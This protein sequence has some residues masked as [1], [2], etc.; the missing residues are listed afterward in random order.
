MLLSIFTPTNNTS[1]LIDLFDSIKRQTYENWEW[2]ILLNGK[3]RKDYLPLVIRQ[4]ERV[5]VYLSEFDDGIIGKLKKEACSYCSGCFFIEVDHDDI[6]TP[7]ALSLMKEAI[8]QEDPD[9][10]YSDFAEFNENNEYRTYS[11][12]YGWQPYTIYP[13]WNGSKPVEV[14]AAFQAD[15][16]S[17]AQIFFAPNHIRAWSRRIYE[18]IGGHDDTL[19]ICDDYDLLCRTFLATAK[20]KYIE[21]C[22]YLYR[23][24][25]DSANT[26]LLRNEEIQKV[27]QN[28]SNKYIYRMIDAW[29]ERNNWR[30]LYIG[31]PENYKGQ[32][33]ETIHP[34]PA[35][36]YREE[37][38]PRLADIPDNSVGVI[39]MLDILQNIPS[40][41]IAGCQHDDFC[42]VALMNELYRILVPG[43]WL[44]TATP[45]TDGRGAWQDP[46]HVSFWNANSFWYYCNADYAKYIANMQCR[47]Q[48]NRCWQ[49]YPSNFH[50]QNN[51][52]Y[53][54]ADLVALKGQ[55]QA[56][57]TLI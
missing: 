44:L 51:I 4:D 49:H 22:I 31:M 11:S 10:I 54:N 30:K 46:S 23:L 28:I 52:L 18:Q 38:V 42:V 14:N 15:P 9:F 41:K 50:E 33:Y 2:V 24:R 5:K 13:E 43:G 20:I 34:T 40:C 17:F 8:E 26:Y 57:V 32:G 36:D 56:G 1:F 12:Y 25:S 3:A 29:V 21:E 7:N 19:S 47:Y 35:S 27:Q 16:S 6:L 45:S 55:R 53:V 39:K 37:I 48:V